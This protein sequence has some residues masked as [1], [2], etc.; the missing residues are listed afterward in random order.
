VK[1]STLLLVHA[2][3]TWFMS[4]LIW[5]IQVVHYPLFA[6][7]GASGY[8]DYQ[9]AHQ[10]LISF[11]VGPVMLVEAVAAGFLLLERRDGLTLAG[12]VLLAVIW[13]STAFL[14]VPL[15]AELTQGFEAA[16]HS[17]LVNTNWIRTLGWTAR[18]VI[19]LWMI[20]RSA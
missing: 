6:R 15:H 12:I 16:A 18:G 11:V 9:L 8:R 5:L 3:A 4:G 2:A 20:H 14:Q 19:A 1:L 10:N 17:R 13:A 7:V